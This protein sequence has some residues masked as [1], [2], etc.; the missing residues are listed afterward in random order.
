MKYL[1]LSLLFLAGCNIRAI[2]VLETEDAIQGTIKIEK[3]Q[4]N[5][6]PNATSSSAAHF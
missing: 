1:T 2:A 4:E 6:K 3:D 5:E